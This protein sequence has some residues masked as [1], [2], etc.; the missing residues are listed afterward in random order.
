M[1]FNLDSNKT[2]FVVVGGGTAGW[3]TA[4]Q[5]RF[6]YPDINIT[7]IESK[8]IGIL[9]AGEGTVPQVLDVL[10]NVGVD[11]TDLI[12]NAGATLKSAVKFTN[13][14]GRG[15]NDVFFSSFLSS[16]AVDF[17]DKTN[18]DYSLVP[19][20]VIDQIAKGEPTSDVIF[21]AQT[22]LK[23]K[24]KF[25]LNTNSRNKFGPI[26]HF[27]NIG[28][29]AVHFDA[30][31]LAAHL[32]KIG[33]TRNINLIDGIVKDIINDKDGYITSFILDDGNKVE[34]NF[35]FDCTGFKRL[36]IGNHYK[37]KWRSFQENLPVNRAI[38]FF[39]PLDK[40][41]PPYT[42]AIAMKY[43]WMWKIPTQERYGCGYVFDSRLTTE[44]DAK[45]EIKDLFGEVNLPRVFSFEPGCYET[46]WVKNCIAVGLSSGFAEPLEATNIHISV[47]S[48]LTF[49]TFNKGAVERD[50]SVI[51]R[52]NESIYKFNIDTMNFLQFHYLGKRNDTVFWKD[53][54]TRNKIG[55]IVQ[56]LY[57]ND[58][59][60]M[61]MLSHHFMTSLYPAALWYE[62]GSGLRFFN[63]EEALTYFN[64]LNTGY[65]RPR[66]QAALKEL[67]EKQNNI[68]DT[69][70]EHTEFLNYVKN[71]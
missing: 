39:L 59:D 25:Y 3:L 53:F 31:K 56:D 38:P 22:C 7:L 52:F 14:N 66:Y 43:G 68:I 67:K 1:H 15:K 40:L 62:V 20:M 34:C 45:Q 63:R 9:G 18:L 19:L 35:A 12:K 41:I 57:D 4:L 36:I 2:K 49:L 29:H 10:N 55:N 13:W 26:S 5:L 64:S 8:D 21:G 16:R 33:L 69:L 60:V 65:R 70:I 24:V 37:A 23:N 42:E 11:M 61:Y 30:V 54:A 17:V 6:S 71:H 58:K 50:E 46:P 48:V 32:K 47:L 51:K 44:E 28:D 27:N